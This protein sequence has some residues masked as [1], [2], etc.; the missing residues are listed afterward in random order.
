MG[1]IFALLVLTSCSTT[2]KPPD[3]RFSVPHPLEMNDSVYWYLN[4]DHLYITGSGPAYGGSGGKFP[5]KYVSYIRE[6][7]KHV[8]IAGEITLLSAYSF[9]GLKIESCVISSPIST[10]GMACFQDS[11]KLVTVDLSQCE[12]TTL[13]ID[14]FFGCSAL[15]T[16]YLPSSLNRI[17]SYAFF[18]CHNLTS[19]VFAGSQDEWNALTVE[20]GNTPLL[21]ANVIFG[22]K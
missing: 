13:P 12:I 3:T 4:G 20:D 19:I 1:L 2:D 6:N 18:D 14:T 21:N 17:G 5:W 22:G 9:S 10:I 16:V 15:K 7:A 8:T 11:I